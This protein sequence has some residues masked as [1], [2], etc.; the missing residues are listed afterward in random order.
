MRQENR[1]RAVASAAAVACGLAWA[2]QAYGQIVVD[3]T[4]DAAYGSALTTQTV[5][6]GFGDNNVATDGTSNGGSELDAGYGTV[7][8]GNLYLFL[9][10]NFENNGN[11]VNVFIA[12]G[13]AGQSTL[14]LPSGTTM[15][16][17]NGS[18]FS[19]GFQVTTALDLNNYQGTAY[20][21]EFNTVGGTATGQYQGNFALTNGIGSG[22]PDATSGTSPFT[23]GSITYGLND[24]NIGGVNGNTGTAA[25]PTAANAVT[26][27]LE[28]SIPLSILGNPTGAIEV[29]AD[30]NGGADQYL[31][32]Q[33]L[34]GLTV[35][36]GNVGNNG[37]FDFSGTPGEYFSVAAPEP[38]SLALFGVGGAALAGR[39]RRR[40]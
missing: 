40:A 38:T 25:D 30:L 23:G 7:Q 14:A 6:T 12:D 29:L 36:S 28:V 37:V 18:K 9:S 13:R 1:I 39:R 34:P 3:G 27:G 4:R 11:H 20:V 33:F 8:N 24:T 31:S 5:N 16:A 2:G 22:S 10:G 32:N 35:G 19:P 17:M 15:S 21:E 26:T